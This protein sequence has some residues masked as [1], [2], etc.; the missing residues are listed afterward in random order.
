MSDERQVS[1]I[2]SRYTRAADNRDAHAMSA[3][4]A[5]DAVVEVFNRDDREYTKVS[6]IQGAEIIGNAVA[7]LMKP[8][9]PRGWSHHTTFDHLI[10]VDG[11]EA[12]LDVQFIVY[13]T[14]GAARPA[15]GW[16]EGMLGAQGTITPIEV[17]YYRP[18]LRRADGAWK[19][20]LHRVF[21]DIPYVFPGL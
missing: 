8:H 19:I 10:T 9:P 7:G 13:N 12:T 21:H 11:D 16:P 17:G 18:R 15:D 1:E 4:F 6:E 14:V 2:M 5:A 20:V 3:L